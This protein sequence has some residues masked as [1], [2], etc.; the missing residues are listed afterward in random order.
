MDQNSQQEAQ[1]FLSN[2]ADHFDAKASEMECSGTQEACDS[3]SSER[4]FD[5]QFGS[6]IVYTAC[7][8]LS[9]GVC[10]PFL[11]AAQWIPKNNTVVRGLVDGSNAA[12]RAA[13]ETL[14][15]FQQWRLARSEKAEQAMQKAE[16]VEAGVEAMATV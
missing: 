1:A 7:Y 14:D 13:G 3:Q 8:S 6:K 10:F 12:D 15:R 9:Y 16:F 2:A 11:L 4:G 5:A